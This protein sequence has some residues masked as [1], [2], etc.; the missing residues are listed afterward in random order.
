MVKPSYKSN[1]ID[2]ATVHSATLVDMPM[3]EKYYC[4]KIIVNK[5]ICVVFIEHFIGGK[6]ITYLKNVKQVHQVFRT[7]LYS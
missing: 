2:W 4:T 3:I 5:V 6:D 1:K 7:T